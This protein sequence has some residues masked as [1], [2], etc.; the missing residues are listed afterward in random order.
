MSENILVE[1]FERLDGFK[2]V[3]GLT[4]EFYA[5]RDGL[6]LW[7]DGSLNVTAVGGKAGHSGWFTDL[8]ILRNL[9]KN[10]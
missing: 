7:D 5:W 1:A 9:I 3:E 8:N 2:I 4:G 6:Y 10:R